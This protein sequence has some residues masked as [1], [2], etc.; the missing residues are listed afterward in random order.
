MATVRTGYSRPQIILHWVIAVLIVLQMALHDGIVAVRGAEREGLTPAGSEL[1]LADLHIA[2]GIAVFLLALLRV[3][4]RLRRGVPEPPE[5]GHPVLRVTARAV[6]FAL[7][8]IILL[9][10]VTGGMAWFGGVETA[11]ELH[12]AAK[13]AIIILVVLHVAGALYQHFA[14]KTDVLRR[15]LRPE[16]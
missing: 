10:P 4:L 5:S 12:G 16:R 15:M 6:H 3:F 13:P 8:A 11:A 14:A 2:C 9:M 7:Y 1:F